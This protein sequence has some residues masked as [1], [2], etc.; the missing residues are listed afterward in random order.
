MALQAIADIPPHIDGL[1]GK[2][3]TKIG[4]GQL[5]A[6]RLPL[7][8]ALGTG[9][10]GRAG[11]RLLRRRDQPAGIQ[12]QH[13]GHHRAGTPIALGELQRRIDTE[14]F[15]NRGQRTQGEGE[16]LLELQAAHFT[17]DF[18]QPQ[19]AGGVLQ[20]LFVAH[21]RVGGGQRIGDLLQPL[22]GLLPVQRGD[23]G[24]ARGGL[25]D[26]QATEKQQGET[27]KSF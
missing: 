1:L 6:Q 25:G 15:G 11:R 26:G 2:A 12:R 5:H 14:G 17:G 24:G 13:R 4:L 23:S 22:L 21:R 8:L 27:G 10:V 3:L 18:R 19:Q 7:R 20:V 16:G 9:L